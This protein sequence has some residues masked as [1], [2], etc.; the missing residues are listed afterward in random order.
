M[1]KRISI[2]T[3]AITMAMMIALLFS[4]LSLTAGAVDTA[5]TGTWG[6]YVPDTNTYTYADFSPFSSAEGSEEAPYVIST[7]NQLAGLAALVNRQDS[8][9]VLTDVNG[10]TATPSSFSD[11]YIK[12]SKDI[13]LSEH[14][15][16]PIGT[17]GSNSFSFSGNFDGAGYTV[18]GLSIESTA[19]HYAGL[20]GYVTGRTVK[21]VGVSGEINITLSTGNAYVGGLVGYA[22]LTTIENCYSTCNLNG[23]GV[24]S[25]VG[26]LAGQASFSTITN[27]YNTGSISGTGHTNA[28]A[29]GLVGLA[30]VSTITNSYNTG[31]ISG[32]GHPNAT[33]GGLVGTASSATTITNCYSACDISGAVGGGCIGNVSDGV[34]ITNCYWYAGELENA[35]GE[36]TTNGSP[37]QLLQDQMKGAAGKTDSSWET[38]EILNNNGSL[39]DA[40]NEWVESN[41]SYSP[42]HIHNGEYPALG[43]KNE[44][45]VPN[46][47]GQTHTISCTGCVFSKEED[48]FGGNAPC[49]TLAICEACG[50]SYGE[51][52]TTNHDS[53]V[54]FDEKGFCENGC[55]EP[56]TDSNSDGYYEI[57][58]AGKLYWFAQQVSGGNNAIKGKLTADIVVNENVL[59]EMAKNSPDPS[60]FRPWTPI[61]NGSNNYEGTFDG[62]G[63]TVSGLY[64]NDN[65]ADYVGLF[66]CVHLFGKVQNVGVIDSYIHG[67]SNVGGVIGDNSSSTV[68]NCYNTGSVSGTGNYVGGVV[69]YLSRNMQNCYNTGS[70]SSTGNYVGGV[71]GFNTIGN[72][73]NCYNTGSVSSTGDHV[74]GVVGNSD[75]PLQNCYNTGTVSGDE[76]VGGVIGHKGGLGTVDNCYN[77]GTVS[78][79]GTVGGVAGYISNGTVQNCY[80]T[81]DVSGTQMYIGGVVGDNHSTLQNCY[82]TG[83]VSGRTGYIGGV[84]GNIYGTATN[85]YY[86]SDSE[87]DNID[88]TTAKTLTEFASGEVAYLLGSEVW[89]QTL[90]DN[91]DDYPIF[92]TENNT[93]YR[94]ILGGCTES[95]YT[96]EYSNT[97]KAPVYT[98]DAFDEKGFCTECDDYQP[99]TDSD[100]DGYYEI[101]N[102]GKLYWFAGQVRGG[103]KAIN[104]KLTADIVVNEGYTFTF[105]PDTGLVEVRK[106]SAVV[107]YLG[108]GIKGAAVESGNTQFD[109]TAATAGTI[110]TVSKSGTYTENATAL[111]GLRKWTP[112]GN[113]SNRYTGVF[114]GNGKTVSGLYFND[115]SVKFVGLFGRIEDGKVQDVGVIDSCFYGNRDI[116]GVAGSNVK[117]VVQNCYNT[118]T[119]NGSS[120]V[121]GVV[122]NNGS[123]VEN[124]YNTGFVSGTIQ[125]VGGVVGNNSTQNRSTVTNSYNTGTVSGNS[126][127][128]GVVGMMFYGTV[129]NCS[130]TGTVN[131]SSRVGGVVGYMT[132]SSSVQNCYN[133]GSV[134]SSAGS[135]GGVV[136][137]NSGQG[138]MQN[139]YNIGSVSGT[140]NYVGG[141]VGMMFGG[142]VE[143]CYYLSGCAEDGNDITQFGIGNDTMGSTT[144]DETGVT[145]A[146]TA[147]QFASGEVALLLGDAFGQSLD[148]GETVDAHP[149]K[150]T[151]TNK[152]YQCFKCDGTTKAYTNDAAL[153]GE[154]MPH[155]FT[156]TSN[157]F[158]AECDDVF[159]AATD[160]DGDGYYEIDNAGKL[161]W[162]AAL[163]NGTLTDGTAQNKSAN[164]I[165]TKDIVVNKGVL[166]EMAKNSPDPSGFRPWT[167][168]GNNPNSYTGTFN[169]QNYTVSG[170]YFNDS[171]AEII[172]LFGLVDANGAV[173]NVGVIDSYF[174]GSQRVGGVVGIN[175]KGTIENCYNEGTVS[176]TGYYVG[177]VVGFLYSGTVDN[178]YNEGTVSGNNTVGGVVGYNNGTID[179]C[180]N[181]GTVSGKSNVG[182]VVGYNNGGTVRDCYNTGTVSGT[183]SGTYKSVGGVVGYNIGTVD[184]C[185]NEGTISGRNSVGGV[186][187]Y[188]NGIVDK[189]YNEGTVSGRENVGGVVGE[190]YRDTVQNCYNTGSVSGSLYVGGVIG[191]NDE[192][193]V[194]NCYNSGSVIGSGDVIGYNN[195]GT[196]TNC[197]Y[198]SD[199]ESD[200]I[201]GITAKILSQFASGEV[202]LLL[203][204]AFGQSL[205]NGETVDALP[206]LRTDKNQVYYRLECDG[207]MIYSNSEKPV[208]H[209]MD[210]IAKEHFDANGKCLACGTQAEA[211]LVYITS[212]DADADEATEFYVNVE[213]ALAKIVSLV[214]GGISGQTLH[215]VV[216]LLTDLNDT[217]T[218]S[219]DLPNFRIDLNGYDIVSPNNI[220]LIVEEGANVSVVN[221][222]EENVSVIKTEASDTAS[223]VVNGRL[224]L[225]GKTV[226]D[227]GANKL[228]VGGAKGIYISENNSSAGYC[229]LLFVNFDNSGANVTF[230][231]GKGTLHID[232]DLTDIIYVD[233]GVDGNGNTDAVITVGMGCRIDTNLD[234]IVIVNEPDAASLVKTFDHEDIGSG[235]KLLHDSKVIIGE[236]LIT[237]SNNE[238]TYNGYEQTPTVTVTIKAGNDTYDLNNNKYYYIEYSGDKMSAGEQ[239]LEVRFSTNIK[240]NNAE[241]PDMTPEELT[242]TIKKGIADFVAPVINNTNIFYNGTEQALYDTIGSTADGTMMY[243]VNDGEWLSYIETKKDAGEYKVYYKVVGDSNHLDKP[244]TLAYTVTIKPLDFGSDSFMV[245]YGDN[246][247]GKTAVYDG[248][249]KTPNLKVGFDLDDDGTIDL[250]LELNDEYTYSF[251]TSDFT[252]AGEKTVHLKAEGINFTGE[253]NDT[254]TITPKPVGR[255]HISHDKSVPPVYNGEAQVPTV[256]V[257][258][259]DKVLTEGVDYEISWDSDDFIT[260]KE[261]TATIRGIGNYGGTDTLYYEIFK[262]PVYAE[263]IAP[264][265]IVS[266]DDITLA[267]K[268]YRADTGEEITSEYSIYQY[269]FYYSKNDSSGHTKQDNYDNVLNLGVNPGDVVY[270]WVKVQ[271]MDGKYH[272]FTSETPIELKATSSSDL[273]AKL[274]NAIKDLETDDGSELAE[275]VAALE[276]AM[277]EA[278]KA[279]EAADGD[280]TALE[281]AYKEADEKLKELVEKLDERVTKLEGDL[282]SAITALE[283]AD[284]NNAAELA[285]KVSELTALINEA[286]Q[287][288]ADADEELSTELT[289]KITAAESALNTKLTELETKLDDAIADLEQADADNA[290]ELATKVSE[291]TA[292]IDGAKQIAADAD[293]ALSTELTN[294]ITAAESALNT[295]LAE[296]ETKL[297]DA[298]ADLEQADADNASELATKVKEL[299]ALIEAAKQAAENADNELSTQLTNKITLAES[300]IY[301]KLGEL[302]GKLDNA[303]M[304][305][306]YADADNAAELTK[307]VSLLKDLINAAKQAAESADN[308]LSVEL[309]GK[310]NA[311]ETVINSKIKALENKLDSAIERLNK[312]D[313]DNAAEL[314]KKV[315]ELTTLIG[316]VEQLAADNDTVLSEELTAK[317]NAAEATLNTKLA[318]LEAKLDDAIADLN[319]AD[320]DNA[321]ELA[322]KVNELTALIDAAKKIAADNDT[323]LSEELT[324]KINAAE[325]TLNTKLAELEAKLDDAIADLNKADTDNAAELAKKV[326][327]L[328]A[329]IDAAKKIAED[330]DT[331]LSEE[332]TAKINA[333]EATLNTK[334]AELEAKLDDAIADLNKADTDNAAELAKKVNEL[335]ALIDAAK[336]IAADADEE[337]STE[338]TNKITAAEATLNTKLAELEAKLDDAIADLNK[339]DT[340]NAAE[341]AK[342]VTELTALIDAAKKIAEDNDTVLS[343]ELTA[344]I[345]T[346]K[347]TLNEK[348]TALEEELRK[349]L[350]DAVAELDKAIA[351]GDKKLSDKIRLSDRNGNGNGKGKLGRRA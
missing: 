113:D 232:R 335:T 8:G 67:R 164:A 317:I 75:S 245:E 258:D 205:D 21:N 349:S 22:Y 26:G 200:N 142:T 325:A 180:Y 169:G 291:L 43:E 130:N 179:N 98:H 326:N 215:P 156:E 50:E 257:K 187:G 106:D 228:T 331:V 316:A 62:A 288:A 260:A 109:T 97:Q 135:T 214:E 261:Y 339:A 280:V 312:A 1:K 243:K 233:R 323:V 296:L 152:V 15:W 191:F 172:G 279:I 305:L 207:S 292:L 242:W 227:T 9:T 216:T 93:V 268:I 221:L 63:F 118:G 267:V 35:I 46:P 14:G 10:T 74:G 234:K 301:A 163:V 310:I 336:K 140:D 71:A 230:N 6:E 28:N 308:E 185:Y 25:C 139:C 247:T 273:L 226:T 311:A 319:K 269:D 283:N 309:I 117:G 206:V 116:G 158:C 219:G 17:G 161:Y 201:D 150:I 108:I 265:W 351:D 167:P 122:G 174:Y 131:G 299:T 302:E 348:L 239:G 289:N 92:K 171:M 188:N 320:T 218:I 203:G 212:D 176:G 112:I 40:L 78:G 253:I 133:T 59:A 295:K 123:I 276:E 29:G 341:L 37:T 100:G 19:I 13:D 329:L 170:L 173:N 127:V 194:E 18:S 274:E 254:F 213:D 284:S 248:T 60:G 61:G 56:A 281:N 266:Y 119:V 80:N 146:K 85:N 55:Y 192:G 121:G 162:F 136:G 94:N 229:E 77:K 125:Y 314:A 12:L 318:E 66:G 88:G 105:I 197:Y 275:K 90:G 7:P 277:K 134:S 178:C 235:S 177:G 153:D 137:Y 41:T 196:A 68:Q 157:G 307:Q 211:K 11:K 44:T 294:K 126:S 49:T 337:L 87:T 285:E 249:P 313:S 73:Q 32:T 120:Y 70:V 334:L 262:A 306:E 103:N 182:G 286:K 225:V 23:S 81:G 338:L 345:E 39:V 328:T 99:A 31:S 128:G 208:S 246:Y 255:L 27:S 95:S 144:A 86:L 256:T 79:R 147:A 315:N 5:A 327:E 4:A 151:D 89:G 138:T 183:D 343:E 33:A 38:I 263:I 270:L 272:E 241:A 298:I 350:E 303:I 344:K 111:D 244:E 124:C 250:E 65:T 195:G 251:N 52:D 240:R 54:A 259:G 149:V 217:L 42:W 16:L 238:F 300:A 278:E 148:N 204:D 104:G 186:V 96:Y 287:L 110:Y 333:A 346:A 165:L 101:D 36:G 324:A 271:E 51:V 347:N 222:H 342:K 209:D 115:K 30:S 166:T 202:A 84:V 83:T 47:D 175:S 2:T 189:C 57:D 304:E 236:L 210:V 184:N 154:T 143:N 159:E 220:A 129:E 264:R 282:A 82:N 322:K 3:L 69:G 330:N 237:Q 91:G 64:F 20:F 223:I 168:I 297:D 198:L 76:K 53:S 107:A 181:E 190:L 114:D 199:R 293:A 45:V 102:A 321:A 290:A 231:N 224:S 141:V 155:T 145:T 252:N 332:L 72:M 340:D 58:N 132:N 34:T 193:T 24:N 160:S 48:H